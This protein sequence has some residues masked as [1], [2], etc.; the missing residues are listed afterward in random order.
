[1]RENLV[2]GLSTAREPTLV[3]MP[4]CMA[5]EIAAD[6]DTLDLVHSAR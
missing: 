1:M 6:Y 4:E 5:R 3:V 2:Y